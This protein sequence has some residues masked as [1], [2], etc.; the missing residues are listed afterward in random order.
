MPFKGQLMQQVAVTRLVVALVITLTCDLVLLTAA[1]PT[2]TD[3]T[4]HIMKALGD[5]MINLLS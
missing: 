5:P 4:K 3:R 1:G 2:G